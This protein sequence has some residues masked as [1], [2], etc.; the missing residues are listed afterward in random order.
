MAANVLAEGLEAGSDH[1]SAEGPTMRGVLLEVAYRGTPFAG[2]AIQKEARTVEGELRGAIAA[3]DPRASTTRGV[4][5]T[6]AGVHAEAQ[7]VAFDTTLP[8]PA[9][10]W[11]LALN[12][13]LPDEIAVRRARAVDV[14]YNPRFASSWKRYRYRLLFDKVRDPAHWDRAWRVGWELSLELAR[15]ECASILGTHDFAAFRSA[16]DERENTERTIRSLVIEA[17]ARDPRLYSVAIEGSAF[18]YN[19]VRIVVG[20]L[21]DVARGHLAPGAF[22]KA[23]ASKDRR[24][25][26][27]TAPPEGLCLEHVELELPSGAGEPWPG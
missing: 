18:L 6:D 19:M 23:L 22:A 14:G 10:G 16:G 8:I 9:R 1:A 3:L 20:S 5:R 15:A 21:V 4:S 26:G 7:R 25:L 2:F 27:Q 11:V 13:N 17:D 24:D 12:K